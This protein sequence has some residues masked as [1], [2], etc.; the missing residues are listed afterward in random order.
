MQGW[1]ENF[2]KQ[3]FHFILPFSNKSGFFSKNILKPYFSDDQ[4]LSSDEK[5]VP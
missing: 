3:F 4:C 1:D 2:Y 5:M